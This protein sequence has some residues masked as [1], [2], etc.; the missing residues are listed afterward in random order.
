MNP[1]FQLGEKISLVPV[2]HGS[3]DF[4]LE[5]RRI[6]FE[7]FFDCLAVPLPPSFQTPVEEA[8]GYLPQPTMVAQGPSKFQIEAWTPDGDDESSEKDDRRLLTYVPVDPCQPVI[9]ALRMALGQRLQRAFIDLESAEFHPL[10]SVYPDPYALKKTSLERFAAAVLPTISPPTDPLNQA[11]IAHMAREL[12]R[13]EEQ[14]GRILALCSLAE[15]PWIRAAYQQVRDE[16]AWEE[17]FMWEESRL[18]EEPKTYAVD[19]RSL[20]FVLGE[21]PYVTSLYERAREQFQDD[22]ELAIDGVKEL[23][24]DARDRYKAKFRNRARA[25]TPHHLSNCLKYIRNLCLIRRRFTPDLYTLVLAAKQVAGDSYAL[26]VAELA[27]A[28]EL[29]RPT[30]LP[31]IRVG[32]DSGRLPDREEV[33]L[34]SRLPGQE[35]SWRKIDLRSQ[36]SPRSLKRWRKQWNP[37]QQCSWPP[38]DQQIESFRTRVIDRAK[39]LLNADLARSEKFTT[40]VRDGVDIR[41]TLRNW[42]TGEIHVK[43]L[44]PSRGHLD[45]AVMLFDSPADPRD[46]PWRTTWFAEHDEESTLA[47]FATD[48]RDEVIG[49]GIALATYGGA[50]MIYPPIAIPDIWTDRRLDFTETLEERLL[51]AGCLYSESRHIAVLSAA[52]PGPGFRRLARRYKKQLVHVPLAKFSDQTIQQLR[53]VHV[54]NGHQVRS[55]AADFIRK[56]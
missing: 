18:L 40:S 9:M 43:V 51:A 42:H 14:H 20:I 44:P 7:N 24:V 2:L 6:L 52:P 28:Y 50:L 17:A 3:A 12:R 5:V 19:S 38:E 22:E 56:P 37:Y 35:I 23:L 36:P 32:I 41:E 46:Y 55:Y 29:E 30:G 21:L 26:T 53:Q 1:V 13:L 4:A 33:Q 39:E 54:L 25:I 15:W 10:T 48:F 31:S 27:G 34:V 49:P 47:F 8:I 11:R 45:T 16:G